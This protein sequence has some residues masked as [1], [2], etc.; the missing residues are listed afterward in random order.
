M[1]E[2]IEIELQIAEPVLLEIATEPIYHIGTAQV[3]PSGLKGDKGDTGNT[4]PQGETLW[5]ADGATT[6]KPFNAKTVDAA[7]ISGTISGGLFQP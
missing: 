7:Y 2:Y 6:I 3:G 1:A 5:E 4:G